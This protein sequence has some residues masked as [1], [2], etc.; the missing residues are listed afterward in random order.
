MKS[1]EEMK[2][3][4]DGDG[5]G[6]GFFSSGLGGPS[7]SS[8][9]DCGWKSDWYDNHISSLAEAFKHGHVQTCLSCGHLRALAVWHIERPDIGICY[10]CRDAA[11][12]VRGPCQPSESECYCQSLTVSPEATL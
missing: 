6:L 5:H 10:P 11:A 2:R 4:R 12:V 9:C 1:I 7:F 3:T 8:S